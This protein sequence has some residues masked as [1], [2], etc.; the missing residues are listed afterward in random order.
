MN[1]N[2]TSREALIIAVI[3][4]A[5]ALAACNPAAA[6]VPP[7]TAPTVVDT[8][9]PKAT[10]PPTATPTTTPP[11]TPP[12][13]P[14]LTP[15]P[16]PAPR[17]KQLTSGG[18][19]TQPSWSPDSK[20]VVFIDK[21][22]DDAP[23]GYYSVDVSAPAAPKLMTERVAFYTADMKYVT[24]VDPV[25]ATIERLSD[26]QKFRIKTGG[27][28]VQL[29]SDRTRVVWT[30]TPQSGPNET[31]V[32]QIMG[33]NIDGSEARPILWLLRGGVSGWLDDDRLL[34]TARPDPKS[35]DVALFVYSLSTGARTELARSERLRATQTSPGSNW[36]VYT[37]N[38]D[39]NAQNNGIWLVSTDGKVRRKL[40][41]FGS[42]QWRDRDRL[43]YVPLEMGK[44][45][46][47]FYEYD[48]RTDASRALTDPTTTPFKIANG[49]WAVS[50]DGT[51]VVFLNAKDSN[52]WL[53]DLAP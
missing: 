47:V 33:A 17:L 9:V 51:K 46:H 24:T 3:A 53:W 19:C 44:P 32:A 2:R 43:L 6:G 34:L 15:S 25:Y 31:R 11:P 48:A 49:D 16:T 26:G 36:I 39:S 30:E 22:D 27:R 21:P 20:Q 42:F 12:P 7:T 38:F 1:S 40:P 50:P 10:V 18:C 37:I 4:L 5:A 28:N 13:M 35:Q 8:T 14:T 23:S 45:S 52:L 41:F 29:S